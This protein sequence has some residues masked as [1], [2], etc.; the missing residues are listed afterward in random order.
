VALR[1]F[2]AVDFAISK[3]HCPQCDSRIAAIRGGGNIECAICD[4]A[5]ATMTL[6]DAM[7]AGSVR[8]VQSINRVEIVLSH[9]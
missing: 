1:E 6:S 8:L 2:R 4:F 5:D 9:F 3:M 7:I